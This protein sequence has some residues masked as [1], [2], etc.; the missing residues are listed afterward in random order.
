M[1]ITIDIHDTEKKITGYAIPEGMNPLDA[2]QIFNAVSNSLI[3]RIQQIADEVKKNN[4]NK[5]KLANIGD[6]KKCN[7]VNAAS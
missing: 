3:L 5:I 1:K 2:I 4:G 6:I 7:A